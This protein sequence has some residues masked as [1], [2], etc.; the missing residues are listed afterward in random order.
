MK[1]ALP[2]WLSPDLEE[3]PVEMSLVHSLCQFRPNFSKA[4]K[5]MLNFKDMSS[6]IDSLM[7]V[8]LFIYFQV[9]SC[10][11]FAILVVGLSAESQQ[12]DLDIVHQFL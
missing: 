1:A 12:G 9:I 4:F 5:N 8:G 10:A 6:P 2:L 3:P 7:L 11:E